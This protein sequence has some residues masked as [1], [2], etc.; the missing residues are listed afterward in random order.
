M[1]IVFTSIFRSG[2]GGGAGRVAHELAQQFA[3][4]HDVVMICP[5]DKTGYSPAEKGLSFYGIRSAGDT[6]FQMP[7]LSTTVVRDLFDFLDAF[8]PDIVHAHEPALIGLIGQVWARMN[9]VPFVHTSHVLPSKAADFGTTDTIPVPTALA[10][11]PISDFAVHGV[12]SNFFTN[13]DALIALNQSAY[14]SI[15]DFGYSGPVFIIPNGRALAHY[16]SK[17]FADIHTDPKI[18]LFIGFL[19]ERKNQSY[20][21]KVMRKL[22][23]H[24]RLRLIGKPLNPAYQ[25][26]LEKYI[27]KHQLENVEFL[28]QVDHDQIPT[29]LESAHV[30]TSASTMEVQSLVVIEALASGTPVVGLSNETIDEL[31]NDD[32]GAW[33]AKNQKPSEFARQV[34]R[35][36]SSSREE[37]RQLCQNAQD[38][39][40][41]LDWSNVVEATTRAYREILTIKLF[42][43]DDESDMLTS[44]VSFFTLG[45]VREYLLKSITEARRRSP[46]QERLLPRLQVPSWLRSWIRV[47]SSTWIIS[48]LTVIISVIGYLFMRRRGNNSDQLDSGTG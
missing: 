1:K 26:K 5:A 4:E 28:G 20:L 6:E 27:Q 11:S 38:R 34:E 42:M 7:E 41:H 37:Y 45:E 35:V 43:S 25:E 24:Y 39:V 17:G 36:C 8:Q 10:R 33:L 30:F 18:L 12:L 16:R 15:R 47:P 31:I 14:D 46:D 22:P 32:V 23:D 21:I 29:Y 19:N 2:M 44:L 40:A 13:C 3:R 9:L 48:G